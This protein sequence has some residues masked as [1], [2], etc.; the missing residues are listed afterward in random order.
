MPTISFGGLSTGMDT[1]A[2]ISALMK[3]ERQP[4]DALQTRISTVDSA[5]IAVNSF[6][7]KMN[8]IATAAKAL[9]DLSGF[10]SMTV[11][12]SDTAIVATATGAASQGAFDVQVQSLAREQRTYSTAQ[13]SDTTALGIAGTLSLGIG[14][15]TKDLTIGATDSLATIA[16]KINSAG[17]RVSASVLSTSTGYKLQV[18]GLDTGAANAV[19]LTETGFTLGLSDPL[20]TYQKATDSKVVIDGSTITRSTNLLSDVI[21]GVNLALTKETTGNVTVKVAADATGLTGKINALV[22]AYNDMVSTGQS[23]IGF[24]SVKPSNSELAGDT[25]IRTSMLAMSSVMTSVF[26]GS[27]SVYQS[28]GSA[29]VALDRNGKLSLDTAKLSKAL[30]ADP[31]GVT[32]LFVG[33]G[34]TSGMMATIQKKVATL[35]TDSNA[36]LQS[37]L[38]SFDS[39]RRRLVTDSDS[40]QA[41][42]IRTEEGLRK[43]FTALETASSKYKTLL[44]QAQNISTKYAGF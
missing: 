13:T 21:T 14:T 17:L 39:T 3:V 12:S 1:D 16:T 33:S 4:Y 28:L 2:L 34:S 27:S 22:S 7:T 32:K 41:R 40:Y 44:A 37:R 42:L 38:D 5:K 18:R 26:T 35:T 31:D 20:N 29:G 24:G 36:I 10:S 8:N 30:A 11:S 25:A 23:A 6:T 43:Q 19:S 9:S 15:S